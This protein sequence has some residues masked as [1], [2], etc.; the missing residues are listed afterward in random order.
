MFFVV[1]F[2]SLSFKDTSRNMEE[3]SGQVPVIGFKT[4]QDG[5]RR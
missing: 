2:K 3:W 5:G 4:L 1:F